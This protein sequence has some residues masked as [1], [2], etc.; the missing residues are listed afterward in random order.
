MKPA[1]DIVIN[2]NVT[3]EELQHAA[4]KVLN[5]SPEH[6]IVSDKHVDH[7]PES[8]LEFC[9]VACWFRPVGGGDFPFRLEVIPLEE[10]LLPTVDYKMEA[11]FCEA[12][13]C[14]AL[15]SGDT[16]ND[17]IWIL[18]RGENNYQRVMVDDNLLDE[19]DWLHIEQYLDYVQTDF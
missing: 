13:G 14:H 6:V 19:K 11:A 18:V 16:M 4:A 3:V 15:M 9:R 2:K 1:P 8:E 7:L 5:V 10:E 17:Y 12:L